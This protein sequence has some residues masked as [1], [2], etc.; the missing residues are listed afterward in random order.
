M[1]HASLLYNRATMLDAIGQGERAI[2]AARRSFELYSSLDPT[3]GNP[4]EVEDQLRAGGPTRPALELRIAA[5]ADVRARVAR[6]LATSAGAESA[7]VVHRHG[8][9]AIKTYEAL[10]RAGGT[11]GRADLDRIRE[12]YERARRQLDSAAG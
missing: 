5:P 1:T 7:D 4:A 6:L 12:Q 3:G 10:L 11:Y 8:K 9:S 2:A